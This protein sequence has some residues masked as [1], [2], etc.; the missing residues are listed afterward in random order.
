MGDEQMELKTVCDSLGIRVIAYS[1][2]GLGM[3]TGKYDASNLPKGPR[4]WDWKPFIV[5]ELVFWQVMSACFHGLIIC[6]LHCRSVLFRQILPGLESLLSCLRRI[7]EKKGKTMSQVLFYAHIH[8]ASTHKKKE[9]NTG[10]VV[11]KKRRG[12]LVSTL[13][14]GCRWKPQLIWLLILLRFLWISL[15]KCVSI[16][17]SDKVFEQNRCYGRS[18]R[19]WP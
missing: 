6:S 17:T 19:R 3:L 11:Q 16:W 5:S 4:W 10:E 15:C 9:K 1:P 12:W 18:Q 13:N 2:L 8:N 14:R 7:A